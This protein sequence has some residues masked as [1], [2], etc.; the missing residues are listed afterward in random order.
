MADSWVL[1]TIE[2]WC[3]SNYSIVVP[4]FLACGESNSVIVHLVRS[5]NDFTNAMSVKC[6]WIGL[7]LV[8]ENSG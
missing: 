5:A 8:E 4:I 7:E 1:I 6:L 3:D 2:V